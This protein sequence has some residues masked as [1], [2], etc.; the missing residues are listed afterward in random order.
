[1]RFR[2]CF[3][4]EAWWSADVMELLRRISSGSTAN[5][6]EPS[7]SRPRRVDAPAAKR[8]ASATVV[9]PAPPCPTMATLRSLATSSAGIRSSV[10]PFVDD[11]QPVEGQELV[12]RLDGRRGRGDEPGEA[13]GR[14]LA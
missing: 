9:L 14:E 5:A 8:S 10:V 3:R 1:M 6:E 7:S 13:A 2:S 12:D 4:H 11:A